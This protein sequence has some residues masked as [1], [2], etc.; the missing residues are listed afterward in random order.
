MPD[1]TTA[2]QILCDDIPQLGTEM[3]AIRGVCVSEFEK[4]DQRSGQLTNDT[5]ESSLGVIKSYIAAIRTDLGHIRSDLGHIKSDL[6]HIQSDFCNIK[7]EFGTT[8]S[9]VCANIPQD[10]V[11]KV[12]TAEISPEL[13]KLEI[14]IT[15]L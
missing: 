8:Q 12:N 1:D 5:L 9:Q 10:G 11:V 14:F 6:S 3:S 2:P 7:S 15:I 4:C 13:V